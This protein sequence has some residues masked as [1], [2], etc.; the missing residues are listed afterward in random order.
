VSVV[1][2]AGGPKSGVAA[3]PSRERIL[4][5]AQSLFAENGFDGTSTKAIAG[6]AGVASGLL[7]YYF[8]SKQE[9]LDTL[10][11]E[12]TLF[13]ELKS[14]LDST[15]NA[16]PHTTLVAFGIRLQRVMQERRE[17]LQILLRDFLAAASD[18]TRPSRLQQLLGSSKEALAGYLERAIEQGKL[19]PADPAVLAENYLASMFVH[20]IFMR[21]EQSEA[22]VLETARILVA[23]GRRDTD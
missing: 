12:R 3:A 10:I 13:E 21:G 19:G 2:G 15:V 7:F 16:D 23:R 22:F 8:G 9:L 4:D 18:S 1:E 11:E 17:L 20:A 14:I 6:R 5:A